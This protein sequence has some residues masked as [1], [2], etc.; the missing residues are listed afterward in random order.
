MTIEPAMRIAATVDAAKIAGEGEVESVSLPGGPA[1]ATMHFGRYE[2][3]HEAYAAIEQWMRAQGVRSGG[4]PWE[5]YVTDPAE[6]P[7]PK[8]W[9]TEVIWPLAV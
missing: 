3:L 2:D 1:A 8:D 6:H 5:D 9:R 7:D 4:A